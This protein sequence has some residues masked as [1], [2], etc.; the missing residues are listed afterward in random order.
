MSLPER[1]AHLPV[2]V[3]EF[4]VIFSLLNTE[5]DKATL[6][7]TT[8]PSTGIDEQQGKQTKGQK[9]L[10]NVFCRHVYLTAPI[11]ISSSPSL[12]DSGHLIARGTA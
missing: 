5:L 6:D 1:K 12:R 2:N 4:S 11:V 7:R 9:S 3:E 8:Q 10:R